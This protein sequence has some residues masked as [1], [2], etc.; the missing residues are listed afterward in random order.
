MCFL[1]YIRFTIYDYS[2]RKP[3]CAQFNFGILSMF[4]ICRE[5]TGFAATIIGFSFFTMKYANGISKG[6]TQNK[7]LLFVGQIAVYLV[8]WH[9]KH[10]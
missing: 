9:E 1:L 7:F 4:Y 10:L 3:A 8:Q 5:L 2:V 6:V